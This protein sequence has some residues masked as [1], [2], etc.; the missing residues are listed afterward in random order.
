MDATVR[1]VETDHHI[2]DTD[3]V[4]EMVWIVRDTGEDQGEGT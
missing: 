2:A 4:V 3:H 1:E